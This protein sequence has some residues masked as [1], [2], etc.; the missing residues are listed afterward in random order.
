MPDPDLVRAVRAACLTQYSECSFPS[1]ACDRHC[2]SFVNPIRAALAELEKPSETM[3]GAVPDYRN[4]AE[5][6]WRAMMRKVLR[7]T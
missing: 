6:C 4:L 7:E 3:L 1:N 2:A 5:H